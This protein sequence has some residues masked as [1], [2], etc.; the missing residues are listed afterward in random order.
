LNLK[1][2]REISTEEQVKISI[3]DEE[4]STVTSNKFLEAVTINDRNTKN[5]I[6]RIISLGKAAMANFTC[7]ESIW[8]FEQLSSEANEV[9]RL[10]SSAL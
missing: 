9:N 7:H 3:N 8:S 6:N 2:N 5:E 1:K 4:L 10:S